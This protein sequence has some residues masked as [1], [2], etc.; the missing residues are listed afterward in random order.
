[1]AIL[2]ATLI[3]FGFGILFINQNR[4]AGEIDREL[5]NNAI[6]SRRPFGGPG[7]GGPGGPGGPPPEDGPPDQ[8][9]GPIEPPPR[10]RNGPP[11]NPPAGMD[12]EGFRLANLRRPR[13]FDTEL[14]SLSQPGDVPF[15]PKAGREVLRM[16]RPVYSNVVFDGEKVRVF[17]MPWFDRGKVMAIAQVSRETRD[18]DRLWRSQTI[19]LAIFLP[20]ALLAAGIGALFL[21]NRAMRPIGAMR[22]A[23]T[24]I[25]EDNLRERL[26]VEGDD[27]FAEL[28]QTFNGMIGRLDKSFEDLKE[29][30]EN[31]K[32]FT[33][34]ASHELR[35]PLTRLKL[36]TS[37]ALEASASEEDRLKALK[38]ADSAA[39]SMSRLVQQLLLLAKADSGQLAFQREKTD[40]RIVASEA[41]EAVV[42][43]DGV[44]LD[45]EFP[46]QA[47]YAEID[48]DAVR[49]VVVNLL[50]NAYRYAAGRSVQVVVSP[51]SITVS[52][53]GAGI[54][55]EHL[56]HLTERFYRADTSRTG[57]TGGSGLGLSICRTIMEGQG[58]RLEISSELGKG[59]QVKAIFR[60]SSGY[61]ANQTTSS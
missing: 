21:T 25:G 5:R 28:G 53:T 14:N 59:T 24:R 45:T 22:T 27:E 12:P 23:A 32:R 26:Q 2:G 61:S 4:V 49:R 10:G 58:G 43:P 38:V 15:D 36:A 17:T 16:G 42:K 1:V 31:Q 33:A 13:H 11:M 55:P 7:P 3:A 35:T 37:S 18:L 6:R 8:R 56:P 41:I 46:T 60:S 39:E 47:T 19:T 52:D 51:D 30:L 50:E 57:S 48:A 9:L 29:A 44:T 34:D 40:L 54:A 20:C